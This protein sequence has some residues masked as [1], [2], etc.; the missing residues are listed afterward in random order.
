MILIS[1]NKTAFQKCFTNRKITTLHR[2]KHKNNDD[3]Q[4]ESLRKVARF[5][6]ADFNVN[7]TKKMKTT[8][9]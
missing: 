8:L 9:V 5:N 4:Q 1:K 7:V 3:K 2:Y 6:M